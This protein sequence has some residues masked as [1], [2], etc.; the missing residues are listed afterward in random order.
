MAMASP[1]LLTQEIRFQT[2]ARA[3]DYSQF[4]KR[5]SPFPK[6]AQE[7]RFEPQRCYPGGLASSGEGAW[8][9]R[10]RQRNNWFCFV[11]EP[12]LPRREAGWLGAGASAPPS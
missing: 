6:S 1:Y 7:F 12:P 2:H 5:L 4:G 3:K 8:S 11:S 10:G 9:A